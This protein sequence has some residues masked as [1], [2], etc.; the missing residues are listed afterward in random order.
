MIAEEH[1]RQLGTGS[2]CASPPTPRPA[3]PSSSSRCGV[4]F[5]RAA[6]GDPRPRLRHR[7]DGPLARAAA[8]R[9]AALGHARPRRR[10]AGG[11]RRRLPARPP[12]APRS[13]SRPG[14]PTSPGCTPDD[15]AGASLVTASALLDLLTAD[16]LA[17]LVAACAGAG[18]PALLTLSVVGRVELTPGRSAGR[19][20]SPRRSTPTSAAR[21]A[22]A[23]CSAPTPSRSRRG[24]QPAGV[25]V[26]V[27]PSPWRLGA[28]QADLAAEWF[29][30]WLGAACE[31][32]AELAG[33]PARTRAGAWRRRQPESSPSPWTTPTC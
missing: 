7:V 23:A 33:R 11:R 20:R 14:S 8:A 28:D 17:G 18:C 5:R 26:L 32:Q 3:R 22:A 9:P 21:P 25:D 27:R 15:L 2:P 12:T 31:Q 6:A 19:P 13:P 16:E 30:G 29:T 1:P 4:T 10:P 24:V